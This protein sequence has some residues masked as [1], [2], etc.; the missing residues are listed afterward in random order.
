MNNVDEKS[1]NTLEVFISRWH[2]LWELISPHLI[3]DYLLGPGVGEDGKG[4]T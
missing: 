4:I 3:V 1:C 2:F